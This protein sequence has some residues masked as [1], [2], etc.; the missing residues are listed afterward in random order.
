LEDG[1]I[2][3]KKEIILPIGR[4]TGRSIFI[5][6]AGELFNSAFSF[7][8]TVLSSIIYNFGPRSPGPIGFK[9]MTAAVLDLMSI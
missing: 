9:K 5:Q 7:L 2:K 1:K 3:F 4:K 8:C 6:R